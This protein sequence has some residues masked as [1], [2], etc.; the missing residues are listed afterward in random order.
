MTA[1]SPSSWGWAKSTRASLAPGGGELRRGPG[2]RLGTEAG[3]T[4]PLAYAGPLAAKS[5]GLGACPRVDTTE[6]W[7]WKYDNEDDPT[8]VFLCDSA[9]AAVEEDP[10]SQLVVEYGCA[11]RTALD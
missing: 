9:C 10:T 7:Y 5:G 2:Q 11:T 1:S 4:A 8:K 6:P 3:G